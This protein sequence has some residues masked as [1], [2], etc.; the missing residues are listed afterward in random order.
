[1]ARKIL[2]AL[3]FAH[4]VSLTVAFFAT[5]FHPVENLPAC[6][7]AALNAVAL[8]GVAS[9]T[10]AGWFAAMVFVFAAVGQYAFT[11]AQNDATGL[12]L[13]LGISAAVLCLTDPGFRRE[14]DIAT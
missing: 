1:V 3:L 4:A 13:V 9:K 11:L 8:A 6:A 2:V 10:R 5:G 14:H 7:L 12:F